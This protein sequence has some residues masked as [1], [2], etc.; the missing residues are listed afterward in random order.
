MFKQQG[1]LLLYNTENGG[2]ILIENGIA[3][4]EPGL[5]TSVY[6]SLFTAPKWWGQ[7]YEGNFIKA[8]Q[9]VPLTPRSLIIITRAAEADLAWL[10]TDRVADRV[11]VQGFI[12]GPKRLDITVEVDGRTV[13]P[14]TINFTESFDLQPDRPDQPP[15][16]PEPPAPVIPPNE[17]FAL[18]KAAVDG[19]NLRIYTYD[20]VTESATETFKAL[21]S[22][23]FALGWKVGQADQSGFFPFARRKENVTDYEIV[24]YQIDRDAGTLTE[25][26]TFQLVGKGFD[27]ARIVTT[28]AQKFQ[29]KMLFYVGGLA[30]DDTQLRLFSYDPDSNAIAVEGTV[31]NENYSAG[32]DSFLL[33]LNKYGHLGA[34]RPDAGGVYRLWYGHGSTYVEGSQFGYW[35]S[36]NKSGDMAISP[37]AA[38]LYIGR[39]IL[40]SDF[41]QVIDGRFEKLTIA[42]G[43][44]SGGDADGCDFSADGRFLVSTANTLKAI[45][46]YSL[47]YSTQPYSPVFERQ[48]LYDDAGVGANFEEIFITADQK[49]IVVRVNGDTDPVNDQIRWFAVGPNFETLDEVVEWR[50]EITTSTFELQR[51]NGAPY[52]P[53]VPAPREDGDAYAGPLESASAITISY[54][55]GAQ[56]GD[57]LVL[58]VFARSAVTTPS[59]WSLVEFAD[60]TAGGFTNMS[61][62]FTREYDGVATDLTITQAAANRMIASMTAYEPSTVVDSG[63][64]IDNASPGT[65]IPP[66]Q[67]AGE[68]FTI[69]GAGLPAGRLVITG[70]TV[71]SAGVGAL[72]NIRVDAADRQA[73]PANIVDNRLAVAEVE[74]AE[75]E[76]NINAICYSAT[77]TDCF[78]ASYLRLAP[79]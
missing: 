49:Y 16:P 67:G 68:K 50:Q 17:S 54:P 70:T 73:S 39:P 59:G 52:S 5:E 61:Y 75:N 15:E 24:I 38:D 21:T 23:I 28:I 6:S 1:D 19:D 62:V 56:E 44:P 22:D 11:E 53:Q 14:Y 8:L 35:G 46:V 9:R 69:L 65:A 33:D 79:K 48:F 32:G 72:T 60:R 37:T 43:T 76:G 26:A 74:V 3:T 78:T 31:D 40:G 27:A 66:I 18:T 2:D 25:K 57:R 45:S 36:G 7:T 30:A 55:T 20:P 63:V 51:L 64:L 71:F 34:Y 29:G 10:L 77:T 41:N 13:G 12:V 47:D 42:G 4:M 58:S